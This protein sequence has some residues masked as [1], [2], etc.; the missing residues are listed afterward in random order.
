MGG[1]VPGPQQ[2]LVTAP[3]IINQKLKQNLII[4]RSYEISSIYRYDFHFAGVQFLGQQILSLDIM[5][6]EIA[7]T[8]SILLSM[9]LPN[10][11]A[12]DGWKFSNIISSPQCSVGAVSQ[13]SVP[14]PRTGSQ[15][16]PH[17]SAAARGP[18][19]GEDILDIFCS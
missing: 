18:G 6:S 17:S 7:G 19:S 5:K 8:V 15:W 1:P 14:M 9:H 11:A 10:P 16:G 4:L 2:A 12:R 13:Y 3:I